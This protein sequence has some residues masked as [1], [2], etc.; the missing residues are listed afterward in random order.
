MFLDL[1]GELIRTEEGFQAPFRPDLF[2]LDRKLEHNNGFVPDFLLIEAMNQ[3]AC[4]AGS[5]SFFH[6]QRTYPVQIIQLRLRPTV[7]DGDIRILA[8]ALQRKG[9]LGQARV[10]MTDFIG[11]I[12][13][14]GIFRMARL[15]VQPVPLPPDNMT[16]TRRRANE[17][18]NQSEPDLEDKS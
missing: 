17:M 10:F 14:S 7:Q 2:L 13:S 1:C 8:V 4:R 15:G 5:R 18:A 11:K 6:D 3:M 16:M 9:L 12:L